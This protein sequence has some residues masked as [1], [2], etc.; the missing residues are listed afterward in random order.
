M[1]EQLA[2]AAVQMLDDAEQVTAALGVFRLAANESRHM[3]DAVEL[4]RAAKAA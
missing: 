2:R 3:P 1:V 4:R